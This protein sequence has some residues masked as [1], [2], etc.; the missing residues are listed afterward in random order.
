[1]QKTSKEI[2]NLEKLLKYNMYKIFKL[3]II[4]Q[5]IA[6]KC[7]GDYCD[8]SVTKLINCPTL[9]NFKDTTNLIVIYESEMF[10]IYTTY[11]KLK[12]N[13]SDFIQK[14]QLEADSIL[15][16][17][18]LDKSKSF[19]Q[20]TKQIKLYKTL[21]DRMNY[22]ILE[23]IKLN[24]CIILNKSTN[25]YEDKLVQIIYSKNCDLFIKYS[26]YENKEIINVYTG[27]Y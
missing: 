15:Q 19:E 1:L 24:N 16:T 23:L 27:S 18:I 6:L 12:T 17:F 5:F 10:K 13:I 21:N 3:V 14:H 9:Q 20:K 8:T 26:N 4:I 2:I 7:L 22:R 11:D 25:L